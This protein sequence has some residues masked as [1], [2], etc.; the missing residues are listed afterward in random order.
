MLLSVQQVLSKGLQAVNISIEDQESW[1]KE[2][3]ILLFR[4][5]YRSSPL[6]LANQWYDL[7]AT[8]IP[9]AALTE[10]E[11]SEQG[12]RMFLKAH[13]YLWTYPRNAEQFIEGPSPAVPVTSN[14]GRESNH[15]GTNA[16]ANTNGQIG[17]Q[18]PLELDGNRSAVLFNDEDELSKINET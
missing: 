16:N 14:H 2:K 6:D 5:H 9:L 7:T 1:S 11:T 10:T 17:F 13:Y 12:F 15:T 3:C 18:F 4:K 8:D